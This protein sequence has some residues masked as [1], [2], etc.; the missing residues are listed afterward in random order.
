MHSAFRNVIGLSVKVAQPFLR[1]KELF[2]RSQNSP[3][4]K[5]FSTVLR[6]NGRLAE[7]FARNCFLE[8]NLSCLRGAII[9]L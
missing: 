6:H 2:L 5:N 4:S 8:H 3:A 9:L 7:L 1:P